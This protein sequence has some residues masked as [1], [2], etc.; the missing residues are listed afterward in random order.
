MIQFL[1]LPNKAQLC[2]FGMIVSAASRFHPK[3]QG[4]TPRRFIN[5]ATSRWR[6]VC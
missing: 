3:W 4:Y 5:P 2:L 1:A 6:V